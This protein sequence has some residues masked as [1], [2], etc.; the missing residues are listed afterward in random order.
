MS[1]VNVKS[2][3]LSSCQKCRT[4]CMSKVPYDLH[5]LLIGN[6]D[7]VLIGMVVFA[8]VGLEALGFRVNA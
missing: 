2:A 1:K 4:I 6:V 7:L 5:V 3:V 8:L